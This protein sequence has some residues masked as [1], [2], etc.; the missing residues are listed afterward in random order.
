[1]DPLKSFV[2]VAA[3]A[4]FVIAS[5][6]SAQWTVT[7]LQPVGALQSQAEDVSGPQQG[8]Y[9]IAAF[10]RH[11]GIWNGSASTWVDLNPPDQRIRPSSA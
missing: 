10:M 9:V 11:A 2:C 4:V 8:G 7:N 6:A 1:M 3:T 5:G